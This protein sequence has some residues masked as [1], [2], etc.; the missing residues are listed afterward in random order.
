MSSFWSLWVIA[1]MVL[2]LGI[3]VFLFL[4]APRVKIP[5]LQD[6]T[7]GHVWAHGVLREGVRNLPTWWIIFSV[8][9]LLLGF[10]YLALYPGFGAYKGLLGWTSHDEVERDNAAINAKYNALLERARPLSLEQLSQDPDAIRAGHRLYLDNCAA[11]HGPSAVGNQA[12][13]APDLTDGD[14]IYGGDSDT[15]LKSILDGRA[16]AMPALGSVLGHQGVNEAAAYVL[17]LSGVQAPEG[18]ATAGKARFEAVCVACHGADGRGNPALGAPNLTDRVWLYGG[19]FP[20]VSATISDGRNGVM[21]AW[22]QRLGVD[23][24]RLVAAWVM[25]QRNAAPLAQSK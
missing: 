11:C 1:L 7:S 19:G 8:C 15:I 2:N 16:G 17:S 20:A 21:P 5:T 3:T 12:I 13:G 9:M 23:Q 4:W 24:S 22:R 18:W 14:W 6:G 10:G 25:A